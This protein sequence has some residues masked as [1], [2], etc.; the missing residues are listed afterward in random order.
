VTPDT[1]DQSGPI[2]VYGASGYTGR[3]VGS[4]LRR[5]GAEAIL[6][7]RN[8][9]KLEMVVEELGGGLAVEAVGLDDAA[10]LRRLLEPCAAVIACAGPFVR[11]G[12]PVVGAAVDSGTHYL[13]TTGEQ[14]YMRTVFE[15]Y[16]ERAE[17]AGVALVTAMGFDYVPGDLLTALVAEGMGEL[18]EVTIAYGV[19][20]FGPTRGTAASGIEIMR[21]GGVEWRGG[22]WVEGGRLMPGGRRHFPPP[23]GDQPTI[24]WPG[25][26][27]LTVPRHVNVGTVTTLLSAGMVLPEP[28]ARLLPLAVPPLQLALRTPLARGAEALIGRLPEGPSEEQRS[29]VRFAVTCEGRAGE[30]RRRGIVTGRDPYGLTA[31]MIVHGAL[32]AAAPGY[33]RSGALAPAQAF[34]PASFLDSLAPIGVSYEVEPPTGDGRR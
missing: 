24:R 14:T 25:G 10:G 3:L 30:R 5:R 26:E 21:R 20:G 12:E 7:G 9:A 31:G 13:D 1:P 32:L 19:R 8:R 27:Q 2:A 33:G 34:D 28:V 6:A 23:V 29:A 15:R 16:G 11:H 22:A 17:R 18:D 4:E